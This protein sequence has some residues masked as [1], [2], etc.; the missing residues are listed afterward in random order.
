MY[1]E[2]TLSLHSTYP[3]LSIADLLFHFAYP[4]QWPT[5]TVTSPP[6]TPSSSS[7][8]TLGKEISSSGATPHQVLHSSLTTCARVASPQ[9]KNKDIKFMGEN[10]CRSLTK[11]RSNCH[12]VSTPFVS[13]R[14][15]THWSRVFGAP[16]WTPHY[17]TGCYVRGHFGFHFS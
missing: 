3:T 1:T 13:S 17:P 14:N 9:E 4:T 15:S 2:T 7:A 12:C 10:K 16:K 8:S 5:A 6:L 11:G